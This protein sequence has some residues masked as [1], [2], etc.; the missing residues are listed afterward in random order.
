MRARVVVL[1]LAL[2]AGCT[3]A[4]LSDFAFVQGLRLLGAQA[5]PPEAAPGDSVTLTAWATDTTGQSFVV[6]W[7]ACT[8][9]S[10]GQ[11]NPGCTDGSGNGLV[12]LGSGDTLSFVMPAVD[13]VAL[14]AP[15]FT[16]GL[17]L[18]IVIHVAGRDDTVDGVY[19]LRVADN[20]QRRNNNPTFAT[21]KPLRDDGIPEVGIPGVEWGLVAAYTD[22]SVEPYVTPTSA[23]DI[24]DER[25]TT[26]WFATAG[27]FPDQ[28]PGGTAVQSFKIDRALPPSGGTIDL[29]VVGHDE[30][31]GSTMAHHAFVMQ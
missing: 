27:S 11:A 30:R 24:V 20:H 13:P 2:C 8:L 15:D 10:N 18:P 6:S 9:P 31:G 17:Y 25:L 29:W 21:I 7:S 3:K 4:D 28:P 14:G 1:A 22:D 12:A 26:Q 23:P 5:E 19:R 16:G